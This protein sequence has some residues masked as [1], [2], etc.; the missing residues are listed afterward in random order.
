MLQWLEGGSRL[1]R[2]EG[3]RPAEVGA[4]A[5]AARDRYLSGH[6]GRNGTRRPEDRPLGLRLWDVPQR[7]SQGSPEPTALDRAR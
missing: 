4:A 7:V 6:A 3:G 2:A 1:A 5:P